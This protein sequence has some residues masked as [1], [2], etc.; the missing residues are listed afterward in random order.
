MA[1]SAQDTPLRNCDDGSR[2]VC[3]NG[4]VLSKTSPYCQGGGTPKCGGAIHGDVV[5][6]NL[7]QFQIAAVVLFLLGLYRLV[8]LS[9]IP[10]EEP[11]K[12]DT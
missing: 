2:P 4:G 7:W 12:K 11:G 6:D 9:D 5:I 1:D 8:R 10:A 3:S